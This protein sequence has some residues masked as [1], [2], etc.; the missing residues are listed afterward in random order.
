MKPTTSWISFCRAGDARDALMIFA[1]VALAGLVGLH[2]FDVQRG[3]PQ[4]DGDIYRMMAEHPRTFFVAPYSLRVFTPW[5]VWILPLSTRAGF[6]LMTVVGVAGTAAVLFLYVRTFGD[7]AAA[8]RAVAYFGLTG[9]VVLLFVDPW[10]VD[11]PT[12][13]SRYSPSCS[14]G[15]ATSV[16]QLSQHQLRLPAMNRLWSC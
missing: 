1:I 16:G 10:L 12:M 4:F 15:V 7:R 5:L 11:A 2:L 3:H 14:S 9:W 6:A 8:L 13:F